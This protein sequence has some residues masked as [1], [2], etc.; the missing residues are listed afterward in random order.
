MQ[1]SKGDILRVQHRRKGVFLGKAMKDFD[2]EVDEFYPIV[3]EENRL[4][5]MNTVYFKGDPVECMNIFCEVRV[6]QQANNIGEHKSK[7]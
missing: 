2:T 5:G 1:V 3:L 4:D 6:V 7:K